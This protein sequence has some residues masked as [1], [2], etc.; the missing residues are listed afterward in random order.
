MTKHAPGPWSVR[1]P[2]PAEHPAYTIVDSNRKYV[3]QIA[4]RSHNNAGDDAKLI[5]EAPELL[6]IVEHLL[7]MADITKPRPSLRAME[8]LEKRAIAIVAK[9]KGEPAVQTK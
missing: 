9:L 7:A 5:A 2:Q 1:V 8:A 4:I 3:A 6:N